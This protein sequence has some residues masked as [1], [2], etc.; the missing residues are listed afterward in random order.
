MSTRRRP[1]RSGER[2]VL[3]PH[4]VLRSPAWRA[5]SPN[6]KAVLLHIWERHNG[7][8]NGQIVYAVREATEIGIRKSQAAVALDELVRL[9]FLRITVDSAFHV[10]TK[11][12]REWA[13][14]AEPVGSQPA[15]KE[16]MRWLPPKFEIQSGPPD[17]RSGPSD[18]GAKNQPKNGVTVRPAGL[19]EA[20][21][22]NSQSGPPDTSSIPCMLREGERS[23]G[24]PMSAQRPIAPSIRSP[25]KFGDR[26]KAERIARDPK[27][28]DEI[29]G[30]L[31]NG[32]DRTAK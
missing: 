6:A 18:R 4:W 14:T 23:G 17:A 26:A 31:R 32:A 21:I 28:I 1:H 15:T 29:A 27:W 12:A 9:G 10:K 25:P 3:L 7:S 24:S 19:S 30:Q 8:N 11:Q 22:T 13:I 5:L 2:F 16:F 20:K